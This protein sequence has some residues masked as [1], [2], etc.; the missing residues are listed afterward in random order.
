LI[1]W[2]QEATGL[3]SPESWYLSI[4][5]LKPSFQNK[6]LG[7]GLIEPILNKSDRQG[8]ATYLETS[9]SGNMKFYER[10]GYNTIGSFHEPTAN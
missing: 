5:G 9:T 10:L 6:G 4:V 8:I 3:V 1:S 7:A 2:N